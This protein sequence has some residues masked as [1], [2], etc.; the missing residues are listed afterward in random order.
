MSEI[1]DFITSHNAEYVQSE[2]A[3]QKLFQGLVNRSPAELVRQ[4]PGLLLQTAPTI[5]ISHFFSYLMEKLRICPVEQPE[6]FAD[7]LGRS[8]TLPKNHTAAISFSLGSLYDTLAQDDPAVASTALTSGLALLKDK[9]LLKL[10]AGS[11]PVYKQGAGRA[12]EKSLSQQFADALLGYLE[13]HRPSL[14]AKAPSNT[15]VAIY[16]RLG[17]KKALEGSSSKSRD[18]E[19]AGDLGL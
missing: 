5:D 18:H 6:G 14:L 4:E 7:L 12:N 10:L 3:Q 19:F 15:C 11:A 17:W 16:K 8:L 9:D 2:G 13:A 1:I